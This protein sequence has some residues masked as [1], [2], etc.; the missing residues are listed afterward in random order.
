MLI[1]D[2]SVEVLGHLLR[3]QRQV[4]QSGDHQEYWL[5]TLHADDFLGVRGEAEGELA[6]PD[7]TQ[8]LPVVGHCRASDL[9]NSPDDSVVC[10]NS[11]WASEGDL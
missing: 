11:D 1:G 5:R 2:V 3:D 6:I 10:A 8:Y 9:G 4:R 7:E